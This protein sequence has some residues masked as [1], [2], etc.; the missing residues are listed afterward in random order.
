MEVNDNCT[1][2]RWVSNL[3]KAD[4]E[5]FSSITLKHALERKLSSGIQEC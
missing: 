5:Y 1:Q 2:S 4:P 3:F